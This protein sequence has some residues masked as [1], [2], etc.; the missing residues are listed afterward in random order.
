VCG[1]C[2]DNVLRWD[3]WPIVRTDCTVCGFTMTL[4]HQS[5]TYFLVFTSSTR[6]S[7]AHIPKNIRSIGVFS[8]FGESQID[9]SSGEDCIH[10]FE[11][12]VE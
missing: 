11:L 6:E 8:M 2:V 5:P 10:F 7:L 3:P 12:A 1:S 9:S 4:P